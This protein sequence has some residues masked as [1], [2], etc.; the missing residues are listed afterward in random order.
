MTHHDRLRIDSAAAAYFDALIRDDVETQVRLWGQAATDPG[1]L[2][3]FQEVHAGLLEENEA[4]D[5]PDAGAVIAQAAEAHLTSAE[6]V[7]PTVGPV[8]VG[9]VADELFRHTPDRLPSE[10]HALNEVLRASG[11]PLPVDLGLWALR[12]WA[13]RTFGT[14][15]V[16]YWK[17]FGE[18]ARKVRMRANSDAEYQLA[19]RRAKPPTGGTQ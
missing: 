13:E 5:H 9:D 11:E 8:T 2:A 16:E 17:A 6:V 14:A 15:P 7:R 19:A 18:A 12:E 3:A 10:A 4:A 1:L